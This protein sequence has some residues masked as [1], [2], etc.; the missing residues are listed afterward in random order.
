MSFDFPR[1]D[2]VLLATFV[3]VS[4]ALLMVMLV[5]LG[6]ITLPGSHVRH[7]R[8]LF[9]NAEGLPSE[10]DVLVHGVK[11]G[12][13]TGIQTRSVAD[14]G[15]RRSV[16]TLV[17]LSLGSQAPLL[18]PDASAQVGFKTALGEPF[19]DLDPGHAPGRAAG[20]ITARSTVEIDDALGF[21]DRS[22]RAN[23]RAALIELGRG[24]APADTSE[25]VNQTLGQLQASTAA[26]GRLAAELRAQRSELTGTVSDGRIVLDTLAQRAGEL[27]ALTADARRTLSAVASQ[28]TA[29]GATLARLPGLITTADS[30]LRSARPLIAKATPIATEIATAAPSITSALR[31]APATTTALDAVLAQ[32]TAIRT[33]VTPA[34]QLLHG[35]A[36][37]GSTALQ[38]LGPALADLVPVAQY[39]GPRG[40]TIAAWF[41]NTADLGG[42]GDAKGDWARFFIGF[43]HATLTGTPGGA[44][45]GNSY[46]APGDAADNQP[47]RPGSYPRLMPY[48]PA[49]G[50]R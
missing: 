44:P 17:T 47:Y 13:V 48:S 20:Q 9:A 31:A 39:L 16:G 42:H 21:L 34:L 23:V 22:G 45:P 49:L 24:A 5:R 50:K 6:T 3:V 43:D 26:V 27:T 19:V 4:F 2:A 33:T 38:L 8:A 29:L 14:P 1:R 41:A 7:V 37:P 12:S 35:L 30:T 36:T 25:N 10:A 28:R 11:V 46:T 18:H 32:A 40:R 15:G